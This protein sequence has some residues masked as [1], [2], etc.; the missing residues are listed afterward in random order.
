[1]RSQ[2]YR[3]RGVVCIVT[4]RE[5]I[6]TSTGSR[7]D[8][9][10]NRRSL[11]EQWTKPGN[12]NGMT[13]R[14]RTFLQMPEIDSQNAFGPSWGAK[15]GLASQLWLGVSQ[16][17]RCH[18]LSQ[19]GPKGLCPPNF[20]AYFIVECFERRCPQ[21]KYCCSLKVKIFAPPNFSTGYATGRCPS[22]VTG[23]AMWNKKKN[24]Q[25]HGKFAAERRNFRFQ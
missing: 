22:L 23:A 21:I 5:R 10:T 1:M 24:F 14:G 19:R 15:L 3:R 16:P 9:Q 7:R 25:N 12:E 4:S 20:L 13:A 2:V 11:R 18:R 8:N 6:S 17:G